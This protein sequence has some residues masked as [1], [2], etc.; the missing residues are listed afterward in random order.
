VI[1]RLGWNGERRTLDIGCGNAPL[2]IRIAK[3]FLSAKVTGID[4]WGGAW[5]YSKKVC[6]SNATLEGVADRVD[7]KKASASALPFETGA[8]NAAVSN[9]AFHEV[10]DTKDKRDVIKEALRVIKNGGTFA[11]QDLFL[12]RRMYGEIDDLITEIRNWE[13]ESVEFVDTSRSNFIPKALRL[14]FMLGTIGIIY[15]KK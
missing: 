2:T 9:L 1:D 12:V 5:E 14:P 6:E 7:S 15:G 4:Y 11:F 13:V 3:R 10:S 8:F